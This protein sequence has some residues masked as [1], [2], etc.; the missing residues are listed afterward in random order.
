MMDK[1]E[2]VKKEMDI[3]EFMI[4]TRNDA[5]PCR[6]KFRFGQSI[7]LIAL[8][9]IKDFFLLTRRTRKL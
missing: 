6:A 3:T 7:L 4:I 5:R 2:F 9:R 1:I 8:F